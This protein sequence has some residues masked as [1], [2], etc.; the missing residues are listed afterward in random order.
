M[1]RKL[2]IVFV[3]T[4]CGCAGGAPAAAFHPP[5]GARIIYRC[6]FEAGKTDGWSGR[7]AAAGAG[8]GKAALEVGPKIAGA[9]RRM[10]IPLTAETV[11]SFRVWTEDCTALIINARNATGGYN[12]RSY[13]LLHSN[14]H[15]GRWTQVYW[16]LTGALV[17]NDNNRK[18]PLAGDIL[19]SL[20]IAKKKVGKDAPPTT[21]LLDDIVVFSLDGPGKLAQARAALKRLPAAAGAVAGKSPA[22]AEAGKSWAGEIQ[23]LSAEAEKLAAEKDLPYAPAKALHE[24]VEKLAGLIGRCGRYY[25]KAAK[26]FGEGCAFAVGTEHSMVRISDLHW[27]YPFGGELTGAVRLRSARH[28]YESFQA[29][30]M[31]FTKD[32]KRV[33]VS[34]SDLTQ[35]KGKGVIPAGNC[36]WR[37]QPYVQLKPSFHYPG[38]DWL[39]PKP[40]PLLPGEPF[41][42][43][44]VRYKP[45]WI[46]IYTP[47]DVPAGEYQGTMTV[48]P[49]NAPPADLKIRLRVWDYNIPLRGVFRGQTNFNMGNV[50]RFY[51]RKMTRPWRRQ[52]YDFILKYR[53]SPTAQYH[54]GLDPDPEDLAFC[55]ARGCNLWLFGNGSFRRGIRQADIRRE[56]ALAEK[57]G[58][59]DDTLAYIGDEPGPHRFKQMAD[60][61]NAVHVKFPGLKVMIGGSRPRKELVGYVDVW[62]PTMNYGGTYGFDPKEI[63][64]AYARGEQV[65]WYVAASPWHPYPNVQMG[66][67]LYASRIIF[68]V[69]WKYRITGFEYYYWNLWADNM[70]T[71]PRWPKSPWDTHSF[72]SKFNPYNG[73][74]MLCYPGPGGQPAASVRLENIRDGIQDWETLWLLETA[75]EALAEQI[76]AGRIKPHQGVSV[77][78]EKML[79]SPA[80]L[81]DRARA[82]VDVD[83]SFCE[84][85]I[86]WTL[87]PKGLLARRNQ[88]GQL[89]EAILKIIGKDA[90]E[91]FRTKKIAAR[92]ALEAKRLEQNRQK[93]LKETAKK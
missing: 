55:K 13:C 59:L 72:K 61:A 16:P 83:N 77:G 49:A 6:D 79:T 3:L 10:K 35:P 63:R 29:V 62:D 15:H 22:L 48:S 84:N 47:P 60:L 93:A 78:T 74:G 92:K 30:V 28:Q 46:T 51:K 91:A 43:P 56:L 19:D 88:A 44:A 23:R 71:Q 41:D 65:M 53:F 64:D 9:S 68:W 2:P 80:R 76:K 1:D 20:N 52:W 69:T 7:L 58:V 27:A 82:A 40:D 87:D 36:T 4:T 32:L 18:W 90:F 17:E 75:T 5:A 24:K 33:N 85:P 34:F 31:P 26:A 67:P 38:Y 42:L 81:V 45:L 12:C 37:L 66:D 39:A 25:G 54:T 57:A 11:L 21:V 70:K 73:D 50:E 14:L 89:I 8:G 86:K